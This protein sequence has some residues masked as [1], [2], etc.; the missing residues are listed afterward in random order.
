MRSIELVLSDAIKNGKWVDISYKNNQKE[1]TYYWVAIKDI[2]LK[3]KLLSVDIFNA[4]KSLYSLEAM[5]KFDQILSAKILEFT[6]Y[7]TPPALIEKI[8]THPLEAE[9]LKYETFNHHIL[10]YSYGY[11]S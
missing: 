2:D 7:D 5:I 1:T 4:Q 8:E 10:R 11:R 6:T 3:S 9:W